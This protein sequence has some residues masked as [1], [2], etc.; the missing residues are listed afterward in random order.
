MAKKPFIVKNGL[1][2]NDVTIIG[3][4]GKL[5]ANN[6]ITDGTIINDHLADHGN[7]TGTFGSASQVPVIT[8]DAKGRITSIANTNVAG[9]T[10]LSYTSA[11]NTL[12]IDTADGSNFTATIDQSEWDNYLTVA[13]SQAILANTNAYIASVDSTRAS[14]P[15]SFFVIARVPAHAY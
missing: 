5:H 2:V 4:N 13:N 12:R 15:Q 7:P 8:V 10:G 9:V 11:N 1:S 6:T 14:P 3:D